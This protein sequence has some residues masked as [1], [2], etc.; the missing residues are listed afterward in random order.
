MI[1]RNIYVV[2][3]EKIN[4][5]TGRQHIVERDEGVREVI[6]N[7]QGLT[8]GFYCPHF[9]TAAHSMCQLASMKSSC[10]DQGFLAAVR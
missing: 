3:K 10:T 7:T 1:C 6:G 2:F 9:F 5:R 8:E 4:Y